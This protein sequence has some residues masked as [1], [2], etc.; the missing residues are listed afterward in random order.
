MASEMLQKARDFET[1]YIPFVP[2]EERSLFHVTGGIGWIN[3]PNGFS[4]YKGEYHL[5]HQYYPYK[6]IWGPMHWGHLKTRDFIRWERL[7]VALAPDKPYDKDG[8]FS[9]SAIEL[10]DGRQ[11]L[12]YTG[13]REEQQEDGSMKPWQTQCLAIGDGVDYEKLEVNPILTAK[14]LP[15]GGS[16]EDFRDPKMWREG[17]SY[18][19]VVGNRPADGSG[20]IL[21]FKSEDAFHWTYQGRVASNHRQYGMMW[22]CPDYFKLDGKDVLLVSPQEMSPM[23]L[24]FHAGNGTV[25][26]IGEENEKKH[27]IRENVHAIDYGIDFYAPQTILTPD[28]RRVM[29]GWM[30]NWDTC[31]TTGYE[32]R[33]WFGQMSLP[34]E[35]FLKNGRLYQQ[36][37]RELSLYRNGKVTY[38]N[39]H[40]DGAKTLEGIEGRVI[41]LDIHLRPED[42]EALYQRFTMYFAQNEKYHSVLSYAESIQRYINSGALAG[43][44]E[45][46]YPIRLK[47]RGANRLNTLVQNGVNHIEIRNVDINPFAP[48][49]IDSRDLQFIELLILYL[50]AEPSTQPQEIAVQNYKNAALLDIDNAEITTPDGEVLRARE[51]GIHLLKRMR[52]FYAHGQ[53][54]ASYSVSDILDYQ[55]NKLTVK[56]AR[57]AD[58]IAERM[59][60]ISSLF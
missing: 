40:L 51:A 15:K 37:I 54:A 1:Q 9:G 29:I 23:G 26:M 3:D 22:E 42:P 57:Y 20:S 56:G 36:P 8:C 45:L 21:L 11:L 41:E 32:E 2:R 58:R 49:G 28:G 50:A 10:P 30:Q 44:G 25:C 38:E 33:P 59:D 18:Y 7:P 6:P 14:D 53:Y 13:V 27:L 16:T 55:M 5:F 47:P 12:M 35:L 31:K 4:T 19:A 46:Y 60:K 39:V 52:A 24:E 34:R 43:V 17:D 48:Q